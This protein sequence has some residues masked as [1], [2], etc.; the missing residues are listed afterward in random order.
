MHISVEDSIATVTMTVEE[1]GS[2]RYGLAEARVKLAASASFHKLMKHECAES[3]ADTAKKVADAANAL[4]EATQAW[5]HR[6][7]KPI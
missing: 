5:V 1:L 3:A 4:E 2:I 7:R 6:P